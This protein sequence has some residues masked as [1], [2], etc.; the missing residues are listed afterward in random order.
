RAGYDSQALLLTND[1]SGTDGVSICLQVGEAD[2]NKILAF[3][4]T[5]R[6][7]ADY[8]EGDF[9]YQLLKETASDCSGTETAVKFIGADDSDPQDL[10]D[11]PEVY[12]EFLAD[13]DYYQLNIVR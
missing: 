9:T 5:M 11:A 10:P 2:Q 1:G 13:T 12:E 6:C 3:H 4:A 8:D 7:H